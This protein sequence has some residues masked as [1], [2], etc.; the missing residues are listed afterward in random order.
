MQGHRRDKERLY[1]VSAGIS[2]LFERFSPSFFCFLRNESICPAAKMADRSR[3]RQSL[4]TYKGAVSWQH[5]RAL[6]VGNILGRCLLATSQGIVSWQ[7]LRAL[8][9]GSILGHCLLATSQGIVSWQHLRALYL[10]SS[11]GFCLLAAS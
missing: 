2:V 11:L 6:S 1:D 8:S 7:H 10:V 5:L 3:G 9:L 4:S